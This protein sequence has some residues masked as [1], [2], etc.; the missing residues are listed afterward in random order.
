MHTMNALE[1]TRREKCRPPLFIYTLPLDGRRLRVI[2][3]NLALHGVGATA[4][5]VV[6][7]DDFGVAGDDRARL[8]HD[9]TAD[10]VDPVLLLLLGVGDEVHRPVARR[11]LE[12]EFAAD[13]VLRSLDREAGAHG[14]DSPGAR[15]AIDNAILEPEELSSLQNEPP[16]PPRFDVLALLVQPSRPLGAVPEL[17]VVHGVRPN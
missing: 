11:Y 4:G 14:D 5:L 1:D 12:G 17:Y 9:G 15:A 13:R 6:V 3:D 7:I 2:R 8:L 16:P 10:G